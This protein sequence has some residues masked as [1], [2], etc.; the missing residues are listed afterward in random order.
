MKVKVIKDYF[1]Q[2]LEKYLSPGNT[3]DMKDD[4]AKHLI[5]LG[6]IEAVKPS[7]VKDTAK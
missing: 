4:R 7:E 3:Q 2:E 6:F 1:D 5:N